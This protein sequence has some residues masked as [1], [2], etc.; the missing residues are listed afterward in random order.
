MR[1]FFALLTSLLLHLLL[2]WGAVRVLQTPPEAPPP[3]RE[4]DLHILALPA[5]VAQPIKSDEEALSSPAPEREPI[6]EEARDEP[7]ETKVEPEEVKEEP[8]EAAP[9]PDKPT[10][11]A[12]PKEKP[13]PK[14]EKAKDKPKKEKPAVTPKPKKSK[15]LRPEPKP[16]EEP[17]EREPKARERSER[18]PKARDQREFKHHDQREREPERKFRPRDQRERELVSTPPRPPAPTRVPPSSY[19]GN[20]PANSFSNRPPANFSNAPPGN[21]PAAAPANRPAGVPGNPANGRPAPPPPKAAPKPD[22]SALKSYQNGLRRAI[23]RHKPR[24]ARSKGLV[25]VAFQVSGSGALTN[26][27]IAQSS[28]NEALDRAALGAVQNTGSYEPPPGGQGFGVQL[29]IRF[30]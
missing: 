4:I 19:S 1:N 12:K 15:E 18:E 5:E 8:K 27:R 29:P 22:G 16:R 2:A 11:K 30:D 25:V 26:V 21:R 20:R 6:K 9:R 10:P 13:K 14:E 17:R 23:E 24:N 3:Y 7:E 28:G